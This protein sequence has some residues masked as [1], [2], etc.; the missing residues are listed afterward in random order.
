LAGTISAKAAALPFAQCFNATPS[1]NGNPEGNWW[2][3]EELGI[4]LPPL[5]ADDS[6]WWNF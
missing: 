2:K 3:R 6:R 1:R 5:S 4:W